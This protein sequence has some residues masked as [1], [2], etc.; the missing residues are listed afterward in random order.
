M[1]QV[2][3]G[4]SRRRHISVAVG[5]NQTNHLPT[6]HCAFSCHYGPLA[7]IKAGM[8]F[9]KTKAVFALEASITRNPATPCLGANS[10]PTPQINAHQF[11]T[12]QKKAPAGWRGPYKCGCL[13]NRAELTHQ[14][15]KD[16]LGDWVNMDKTSV[17]SSLG[18]SNR[19]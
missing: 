9:P 7:R 6:G 2:I 16:C 19:S 13:T 1:V 3:P 18:E 5:R 17:F 14:S 11:S 8:F 12:K 4:L 10:W 15:Q